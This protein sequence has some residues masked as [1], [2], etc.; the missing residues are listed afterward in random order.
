MLQYKV[1]EIFFTILGYAWSL[2]LNHFHLIFTFT[3]IEEK[4]AKRT[5]YMRLE[6]TRTR[7]SLP[8]SSPGMT[9]SSMVRV[10]RTLSYPCM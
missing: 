8:T 7:I 5:F 1:I 3:E 2:H 4:R 6:E 9:A 10:Q